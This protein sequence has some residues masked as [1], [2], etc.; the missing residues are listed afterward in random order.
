MAG[1]ALVLQGMARQ[2]EARQGMAWPGVAGRG[3]AGHG[4]KNGKGGNGCKAEKGGIEPRRA[5]MSTE[6]ALWDHGTQW[7]TVFGRP[8]SASH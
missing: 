6:Q 5:R 3:E 4:I 1:I 2:G 7:Q 8:G